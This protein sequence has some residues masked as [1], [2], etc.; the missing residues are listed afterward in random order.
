MVDLPVSRR[1]L[2]ILPRPVACFCETQ[3][4]QGLV[5]GKDLTRRELLDKIED[6]GARSGE[7]ALP[8]DIGRGWVR[9]ACAGGRDMLDDIWISLVRVRPEP[10]LLH[11]EEIQEL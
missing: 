4:K 6:K 8:V 5:P 7:K 10:L 3:N 11:R 1:L 2:L 9:C